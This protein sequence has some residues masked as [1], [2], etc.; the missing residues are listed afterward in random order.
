VEPITNHRVRGLADAGTRLQ[1]SSAT[2]ANGGLRFARPPPLLPAG[3]A[4]PPPAPRQ[5]AFRLA[6]TSHPDAASCQF[7]CSTMSFISVRHLPYALLRQNGTV[8]SATCDQEM[9]LPFDREN[10]MNVR[11]LPGQSAVASSKANKL[12]SVLEDASQNGA[13]LA[14]ID[15]TLRSENVSIAAVPLTDFIPI[16]CRLAILNLRPIN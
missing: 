11:R 1:Y 15:K 13:D 8:P 7:S 2:L 14:I 12:P 6:N 5:A 10:R 4:P 9:R 16:P 3:I